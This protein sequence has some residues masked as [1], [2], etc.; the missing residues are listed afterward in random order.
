MISTQMLRGKGRYFRGLSKR[1]DDF[2][3]FLVCL[4]ISLFISKLY[5]FDP[6][7]IRVKV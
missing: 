7:I 5:N 1:L 2:R 4:F 3:N 6:Y